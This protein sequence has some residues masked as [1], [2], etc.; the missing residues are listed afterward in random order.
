LAP[1]WNWISCVVMGVLLN[2][3]VKELSNGK[4]TKMRPS[5][6]AGTEHS[7]VFPLSKEKLT[8]SITSF[9]GPNLILR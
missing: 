1:P 8:G 4:T 2:L 9:Q 5:S 7:L 6:D 3:R